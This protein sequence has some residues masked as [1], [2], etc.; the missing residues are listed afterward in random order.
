MYKFYGIGTY[1]F[2]IIA[3]MN[4]VIFVQ[5]F[6]Q[7]EIAAEIISRFVSLIFNYALFGFFLHLKRSLPPKNIKQAS[8]EEMANVFEKEVQND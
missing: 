8:V 4:T 1:C 6:P 3:V 2:G 5:V 7:L